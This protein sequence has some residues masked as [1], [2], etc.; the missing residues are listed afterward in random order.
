MATPQEAMI[1]IWNK[2]PKCN[3]GKNIR[4]IPG[5]L[6]YLYE[7][8]F[9]DSRRYTVDEWLHAFIPFKQA[10]DTYLLTQKEFIT[11]H[12]YRDFTPVI[13]FDARALK[14]GPWSDKALQ[15]LYEKYIVPV[16]N[17]KKTS[18]WTFVN[19]L[20]ESKNTD[21]NGQLLFNKHSKNS[22][23]NLIAEYPSPRKKLEREAQRIKYVKQ[24]QVESRI[25]NRD[26]SDFSVGENI[27][28]TTKTSL[29][30]L[31]SIHCEPKPKSLKNEEPT[32][33]QIDVK[34]LRKP[35]GKVFG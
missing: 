35:G 19:S 32:A 1:Y 6:K 17:L 23:N 27:T 15:G 33:D 2:M 21:Q 29:E 12:V 20:K 25:N 30:H 16:S 22:L 9:V 4:Y 31:E 26:K 7:H 14:D 13:N 11:L 34:S 18:F 3:D 10:D 8:G 24:K 28:E 5:D